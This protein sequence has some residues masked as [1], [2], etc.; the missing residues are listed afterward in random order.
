MTDSQRRFQARRAI[1]TASR[2]NGSQK[3]SSATAPSCRSF[4]HSR[5]SPVQATSSDER[6]GQRPELPRPVVAADQLPAEQHRGTGDHGV[7][8]DEQVRVGRADVH[9]DPRRDAGQRRD[10]DQPGPAAEERGDRDR[11][12]RADDDGRRVDLRV[13]AGGEVGG[14]KRAAE[15]PAAESGEPQVA[16]GRDD[17]EREPGG[18]DRAARVREV[19]RHRRLTITIA[20]S[21]VA[22]DAT[23]P[24]G[25]A[26]ASAGRG[27][28]AGR[29]PPSRSGA[30]RAASARVAS[31]E[32]RTPK[33]VPRLRLDRV[34]R[35]ARR[36]GRRPARPCRRPTL[37][38][39]VLGGEPERGRRPGGTA[40]PST[41]A[42]PVEARALAAGRA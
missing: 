36:T 15:E 31:A 22:G 19:G 33:R 34:S 4:V 17:H 42:V 28:R 35:R 24:A 37:P 8:R 40:L 38:G 13:P 16:A 39:A 3:K 30:R 29:A 32:T 20:P 25:S 5:L 26:R 9:R 6:P 41:F 11:A 18:S 1:E 12:D 14:E 7:E 10:G 21:R 23:R 27:G 2:P